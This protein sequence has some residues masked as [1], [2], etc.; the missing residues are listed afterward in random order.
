MKRIVKIATA[1]VV[2]FSAAALALPFLVDANRF[3]PMLEEQLSQSLG[4]AVHLGYLKVSLFSGGASASEITIADDAR[5]GHAPFLTAKS[6]SVGVKWIPLLF[7]HSLQVTGLTVDKPEIVLLQ[8]PSGNWNFAS[9]GAHSSATPA[10]AAS[11]SAAEPTA[12][13]VSKVRISDGRVTIAKTASR[14]KPTVLDKVG[15]TLSDFA[16]SS[17][18]PFQASARVD[19]QGTVKLKGTVGPLN[20]GDATASPFNATVSASQVRAPNS[21]G[22]LAMEAKAASDG[23]RVKLQGNVTGENLKFVKDGPASPKSLGFDFALTHDLRTRAGALSKGRVLIGKAVAALTGTY[24]LAGEAKSLN[25]HLLGTKM[26][27]PELAAVLPSLGVLLPAGSS[28]DGGTAHV[29]LTMAGPVDRLVSTG[30]FGVEAAKLTGFDLGT[31]MKAVAALAG[32]R[33]AKDTV[34]Q[35]F[36]TNARVAP[37]GTVIDGLTLAAE[38]IGELT[39]GGTINSGHTLDFKMAAK[40]NTGGTVL[41]ALGQKGTTTL[42]FFIRGTLKDPIF[43]PDAR[44]IATSQAKSLLGGKSPASAATGLIRGLFGKKKEAPAP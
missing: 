4:R 29:D 15:V 10:P 14:A 6:L 43:V 44:A 2:L 12:L 31:K 26:P 7:S 27:V 33:V 35:K 18:F 25:F 32:I 3:R 1:V 34:I 23:R 36:V 40:M 17:A 37:D 16:M 39:G 11:K 38:G 28:L 24:N 9:L 22:R 5:F 13:F 41:A 8:T 42:P 30:S 20:A 19:G 21:E